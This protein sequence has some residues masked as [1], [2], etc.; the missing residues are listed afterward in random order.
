MDIHAGVLPA[1][2]FFMEPEELA[3]FFDPIREWLSEVIHLTPSK[4]HRMSA[5]LHAVSSREEIDRLILGVD[6]QDQ[7]QE[8]AEAL[9][10]E[11]AQ[12]PPVP[13]MPEEILNPAEWPKRVI[14]LGSL[15]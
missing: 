11:P 15:E 3:V 1:G 13:Q 4:L 8:L 9:A 6:N 10:L 2:L 5:L 14:K 12:L 7:L